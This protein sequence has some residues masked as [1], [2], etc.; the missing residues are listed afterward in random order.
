[1]NVRLFEMA[2]ANSDAA[3]AFACVRADPLFATGIGG[4]NLLGWRRKRK[5]Q[6]I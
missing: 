3:F 5:A 2:R 4:F 1:M 6:P